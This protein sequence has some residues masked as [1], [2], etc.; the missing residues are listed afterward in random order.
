MSALVGPSRPSLG[1]PHTL[2]V[3]ADV[4]QPHLLHPFVS[5]VTVPIAP[6]SASMVGLLSSAVVAT[7]HALRWIGEWSFLAQGLAKVESRVTESK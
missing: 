7:L 3:P 1:Q 6:T 4:R 5:R 2:A